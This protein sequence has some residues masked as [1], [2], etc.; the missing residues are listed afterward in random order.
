MIFV[1]LAAILFSLKGIMAKILYQ[2]GLSISLLLVWRLWL[3][4]IIFAIPMVY[5][6]HFKNI[7]LK[8]I[9]LS[10]VVGIFFY[11]STI[12]DFQALYLI[13]ANIERMILFTYP[14]FILIISAIFLKTPIKI[15]QWLTLFVAQLGL[16]LLMGAFSKEIPL[17]YYGVLAALCASI[18]YGSGWIIGQKSMQKITPNEH[19]FWFNAVSSIL[20]LGQYGISGGSINEIFAIS[21]VQWQFLAL[22]AIFCTVLPFYFLSMG[23]QKIGSEKSGLISMIGPIVTLVLT[24]YLLG[25]TLDYW[26]LLGAFI[27]LGAIASLS[28]PKKAWLALKKINQ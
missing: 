19:N 26:Q 21:W 27:I 24:Y 17:N 5:Y 16:I 23:I 20:I 13:P 25:E 4:L 10:L 11:L 3:A 1:M 18:T 2:T 9:S 22:M 8:K 6:G 15:S 7:S 14:C 12:A 28:M